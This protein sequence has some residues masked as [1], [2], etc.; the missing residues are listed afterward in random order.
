M[1]IVGQVID[2]GE[3]D[4]RHYRVGHQRRE[5]DI[6]DR[7]LA[8]TVD[9]VDQTAADSLDGGDV[10]LHRSDLAVHGLGA[11]RD[12]AL[13]GLGC[14]GDA[15]GDRAYRWTVQSGEGL[16]KALRLGIEDKV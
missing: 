10:E 5:V 11:E 15:K 7:P 3:A 9:E 12:R 14:V 8:V 1:N 16:G 13:V 6:I 2:A 4:A